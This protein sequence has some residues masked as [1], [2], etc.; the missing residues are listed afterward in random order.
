MRPFPASR[1]L[2]CTYLAAGGS[3][4]AVRRRDGRRRDEQ[5]QEEQAQEG[6]ARSQPRHVVQG[7]EARVRTE[8]TVDFEISLAALRYQNDLAIP[9]ASS[10]NENRAGGFDGDRGEPVKYGVVPD[11][12][13]VTE[14]TNLISEAGYYVKSVV[15]H[16]PYRDDGRENVL[17]RVW[18]IGGRW[19][20]GVLPVDF[21]INVRGEELG[22]DDSRG[23]IGWTM[24][25]VTVHG[26]YVNDRDLAQRRMIERR[27]GSPST[28]WWR[29][30]S[31]GAPEGAA[32]CTRSPRAAA[33]GATPDRSQARLSVTGTPTPPIVTRWSSTPRSSPRN[34]S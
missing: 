25:Q 32:G 27:R 33:D 2:I 34:Q 8:V 19:Y 16:L 14:L 11:Y 5:A 28:K 20:E 1:V 23:S 31:S 17:N 30:C 21:G 29:T 4:R 22:E 15:E 26:S 12:R 7:P 6:P 24:A 18:D 9:D 3:T 13:L 10:P